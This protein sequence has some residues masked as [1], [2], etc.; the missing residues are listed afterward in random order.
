M[1]KKTHYKA[2]LSALFA[3]FFFYSPPSFCRPIQPQTKPLPSTAHTGT[4]ANSLNWVRDQEKNNLCRGHFHT[5]K[6]LLQQGPPPSIKNTPIE[7]HATG[8]NTIKPNNGIS[9]LRGQVTLGQP[10][11]QHAGR[12][13]HTTQALVNRNNGTIQSIKFPQS[14]SLQQANLLIKAASGSFFPGTDSYTF[15]SVLYHLKPIS[16]PQT[17][18]PPARTYWGKAQQYQRLPNG[19]IVLKNATCSTCNPQHASWY[20]KAP[21]V[22]FHPKQ[23]YAVAKN[24]LLYFHHIP[25]FYFP[26]F[27]FPTDNSR[28]SGFLFPSFSF[29]KHGNSY[30][31]QPY[32]WNLAPNYDA[33]ITAGIYKNSGLQLSTL[34]RYLTPSASGQV[35]FS[36]LPHDSEFDHYKTSIRQSGITGK[37]TYINALDKMNDKRGFISTQST[38]ALS[39]NLSASLNLN[40]VT[41]PYFFRDFKTPQATNQNNQLTN[42]IQLNYTSQHWQMYN[43]LSAYQP[44]HRIDSAVISNQYQRLPE[45]DFNGNYDHITGPVFISLNGQYVNFLY[46]SQ[47]DP[48]TLEKNTGQR[49]HL[50]PSIGIKWSNS[51]GYITPQLS[52]DMTAYHSQLATPLAPRPQFDASRT[53]PVTS[54]DSGLFLE[55][56]LNLG[57]H[58][59]WQTLEPRLKYTYIPYRNQDQFPVYDTAITPPGFSSLFS[60]NQFTGFDRLQNT[61]QF[62]LGLTSRFL[63]QKDASEVLQTDLGVAYFMTPQKVCLTNQCQPES[64]HV[65]PLYTDLSFNPS[66]NLTVTAAAAWKIKNRY[67]DNASLSLQYHNQTKQAADITY[68]DSHD[69]GQLIKIGATT[70]LTSQLSTLGYVEYNINKKQSNHYLLGI[71][72]DTC[73]WTAQLIYD[74]PFV[75]AQ[76]TPSN[77][78]YMY[79]HSIY[80]QFML[81]G[82]GSFGHGT[83]SAESVLATN[84]PDFDNPFKK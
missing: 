72:Y 23:Q 63:K 70:P 77:L 4:I 80:F 15:N 10:S 27:I 83:G 49:L 7:L 50:A 39:Q 68:I 17:T 8:P 51:E 81:K 5:P 30:Y 20:L 79:K 78:N 16:K 14:F 52:F 64:P 46:H 60:D 13:A 62:S 58:H 9:T 2:L 24:M 21:S 38:W 40:T 67:M 34:F 11:I 71:Q 54:I 66:S 28:H 29:K 69:S 75:N 48:V 25:V 45:I 76:T 55:K 44:L 57:Q 56:S 65:S 6:T 47:F 31:Q 36:F 37:D 12:I 32:Y 18:E 19:N 3:P 41:D 22:I 1:N 84:I 59:Y 43:I 53:I 26:Y 61:S 73:C 74:N 42:Q 35:F 33:T 82:L